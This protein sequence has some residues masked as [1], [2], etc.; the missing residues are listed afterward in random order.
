M[1]I[2]S[3]TNANF[4]NVNAPS[5]K[6]IRKLSSSGEIEFAGLTLKVNSFTVYESLLDHEVE[7]QLDDNISSQ[8]VLDS[9]IIDDTYHQIKNI[10]IVI[11]ESSNENLHETNTKFPLGYVTFDD[12]K[13][14]IELTEFNTL[15]MRIHCR[16]VY[17]TRLCS[18]LGSSNFAPLEIF[19]QLPMIIGQCPTA[20]PVMGYRFLQSS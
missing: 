2:K 11:A 15:D 1:G 17:F 8:I 10:R 3:G 19:I 14:V 6:E 12:E 4:T 20:V 16:S 5:F 18:T 9:E 7:H 13:D